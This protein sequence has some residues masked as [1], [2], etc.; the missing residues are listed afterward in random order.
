MR[1]INKIIVHCSA[2]SQKNKAS[3]IVA[4][5]LR[6]VAKGGRGW[7]VPGYHY[8]IEADGTVVA[9]VPEEQVSNGVAGQNRQPHGSTA[10]G[11]C[12]LACTID[13]PIPHGK[14]IWAPRFR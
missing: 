1:I 11:T 10:K 14:D 3:D 7:K 8:I 2:G 13:E 9:T 12:E 6:P 5:H 4:Y